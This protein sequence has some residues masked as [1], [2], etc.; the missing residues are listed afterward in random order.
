MRSTRR[1]RP[2]SVPATDWF[3]P[4]SLAT[5]QGIVKSALYSPAAPARSKDARGQEAS[6]RHD[7]PA[8]PPE[9]EWPAG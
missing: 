2:A 1:T 3:R 5:V 4:D 8:L 9:W 6:R 7:P